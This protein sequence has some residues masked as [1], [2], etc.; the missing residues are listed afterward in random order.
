MGDHINSMESRMS[1]GK[2]LPLGLAL[3]CLPAGAMLAA[4]TPQGMLERYT[5][6]AQQ[7]DA[8]F[9]PAA[10]RGKVF[11][12]A[13]HGKDW[14]CATCHTVNPRRSGS[15]ASTHKVISPLSPLANPDRF[16]DSA[17]TDKWFRRNCND[18]LGRECNAPEKA[19]LL[20]WLLTLK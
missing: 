3:A 17:K 10:G 7:V 13:T 2:W 1:N 4:E 11:Y 6:A 16:A 8:G 20:S 18:V 12:N 15:H 14:S 9:T 5:L 19:D